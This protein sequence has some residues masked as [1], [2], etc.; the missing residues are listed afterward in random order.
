V[1]NDTKYTGLNR[2]LYKD[3]VIM[4]KDGL[5]SLRNY[6]SVHLMGRK[7]GD[8]LPYFDRVRLR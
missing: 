8:Y 3:I 1:T 2:L 6:I 5:D 7:V 4:F